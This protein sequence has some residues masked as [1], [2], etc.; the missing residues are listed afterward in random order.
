MVLICGSIGL[1][2]TVTESLRSFV[3]SS[4]H[5]SPMR[6]YSIA[7]GPH[8]QVHLFVRS[9]R[10]QVPHV[11]TWSDGLLLIDMTHG[12][13]PDS[14][15]VSTL[16]S[17]PDSHTM[18]A[19]LSNLMG[20][21]TLY[22][23]I[24]GALL[25]RSLYMMRPLYYSVIQ[26]TLVFSTE[27]LALLPISSG[28]VSVIEPGEYIRYTFTDHSLNIQTIQRYT[29]LPLDVSL[30][31]DVAL[32]L[33]SEHLKTSMG[34]VAGEQCA[35]LFSGGVDSSLAAYLAS[36]VCSDI[37]LFCVSEH[38]AADATAS[39]TAAN[40]LGLPLDNI[41]MDTDNVWEILPHVIHAIGSVDPMDVCIA[42]PF[43]IASSEARQRGHTNMISG[44]GP[45]ELFAG[46]AKH[47]QIYQL[48]GSEALHTELNHEVA[49]THRTNIERDERAIAWG[50]C[51]AFFPYL[52]GPF[53][54]TALSISPSWKVSPAEQPDRKIFFRRFAVY[55]GLPQSL[56]MRTKHATQY[57]SGSMRVLLRTL[58]R[59]DSE[60][61]DMSLRQISRQLPTILASV[62]L[63]SELK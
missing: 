35:V 37:G 45:D 29:L 53:I 25:F 56:A 6:E 11:R 51:D 18:L 42:L 26:S 44:Q 23:D 28:V 60:C 33:L 52:Y 30:S 22:V 34:T 40:E 38:S 15:L 2:D 59:H 46:Y 58:Q 5:P 24:R 39:R 19:A 9:H 41:L 31:Q 16:T 36:N 47:V 55:M 14:S 4:P 32:S 63:T 8:E 20:C 3:Q 1:T 49:V 17:T 12:R 13:D 7:L 62:V 10:L 54:K 61:R 48:H 27:P 57:S 21:F 50:G 43:A